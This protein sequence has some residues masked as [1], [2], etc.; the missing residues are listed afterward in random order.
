MEAR[1][2]EAAARHSRPASPPVTTALDFL[3]RPR[4]AVHALALVRQARRRRRERTSPTASSTAATPMSI[5]SPPSSTPV[6]RAPEDVFC[7]PV[8]S[9]NAWCCLTFASPGLPMG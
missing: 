8:P 1:R 3:T 6:S 7:T 2:S 4:R 9:K 5:G